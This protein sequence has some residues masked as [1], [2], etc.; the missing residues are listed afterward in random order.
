MYYL[1]FYD[2]V[3]QYSIILI[4]IRVLYSPAFRSA[5]SLKIYTWLI[6]PHHHLLIINFLND[7]QFLPIRPYN[8]LLYLF[9]AETSL[10]RSN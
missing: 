5:N 2:F 6:A 1:E 3:V 7:A 8:K 9:H 10:F 4:F